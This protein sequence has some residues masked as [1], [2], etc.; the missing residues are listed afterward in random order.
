VA[1]ELGD[2]LWSTPLFQTLK[3]GVA[4]YGEEAFKEVDT[5]VLESMYGLGRGMKMHDLA[6]SMMFVAY[7]LYPARE[8]KRLLKENLALH[9]LLKAPFNTELDARYVDSGQPVKIRLLSNGRQASVEG[10]VQSST[11]ESQTLRSDK[12]ETLNT[13]LKLSENN[14]CGEV[15]TVTTQLDYQYQPNLQTHTWTDVQSLIA[16]IPQLNQTVRVQNSVI[17][18]ATQADNG[19]VNYGFKSFNFIINDDSQRIDDDLVI[20]VKLAHD[21]LQDVKLVLVSPAGTRQTL[22]A[23]QAYSQ[24]SRSLYWV[25][26]HD[27]QAQAFTGES[28]A[29]T[30]RLEITDFSLGDAGSLIEWSVGRLTGYNC[31]QTTDNTT[32]NNNNESGSGGGSLSWGLLL[33]SGLMF[34]RRERFNSLS[35]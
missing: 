24:S 1:G 18:D 19:S 4:L 31:R 23:N 17:P 15:F 30:W 12:F 2:E 11:G 14:V 28:L 6:E 35:K 7:K 27:A 22:M 32:E 34:W 33:L 16:G 26:Q 29:G 21:N 10:R 20:Y 8:Y 13:E 5:L 9:G 25:G 3:Q